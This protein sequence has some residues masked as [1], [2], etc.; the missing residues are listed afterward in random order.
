MV[1]ELLLSGKCRLS[2][3]YPNES[4]LPAAPRS[5]AVL[6]STLLTS[7]FVHFPSPFTMPVPFQSFSLLPSR[8]AIAPVTNGVA[9]DVPLESRYWPPGH[10]D[11]MASPGATSSTSL[12]LSENDDSVLSLSTEP[13]PITSLY[14]AG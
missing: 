6:S 12:P 8:S 13:T 11:L 9:I 3:P 5:L 7:S 4:S 2:R 14:A 1:T 10:V